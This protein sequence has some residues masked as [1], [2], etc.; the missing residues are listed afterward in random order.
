MQ[1]TSVCK[2]WDGK[3]DALSGSMQSAADVDFTISSGASGQDI[4]SVTEHKLQ[5]TRHND[6]LVRHI[7]KLQD[8]VHDLTGPKTNGVAVY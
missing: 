8:I 2:T 7:A 1:A 5:T 3:G 4:I 6:F